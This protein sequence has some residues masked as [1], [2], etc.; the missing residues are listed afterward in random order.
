MAHT[1]LA[2]FLCVKHGHIR[3]MVGRAGEPKGSPGYM[4]TGYANPVRLTTSLIGVNGGDYSS[5]EMGLSS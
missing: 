2:V 5:I 1:A 4:M 3:I